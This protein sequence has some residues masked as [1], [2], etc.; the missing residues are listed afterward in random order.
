MR[1]IHI[2]SQKELTGAEAYAVHLAE[3][4]QALGH[5]VLIISDELHLPTN[6]PFES[7]SVHQPTRLEHY[8]NFQKLRAHLKA[9]QIHIIHAHSRAAVRLASAARRGTSVALITT[10]H[11]RQHFSWSKRLRD[12]YGDRVI[13]ICE[14]VAEHLKTDFKMNPRK[15]WT[16]RNPFHLQ[17]LKDLPQK[18]TQEPRSLGTD[19]KVENALKISYVGRFSGPKGEL[20]KAF[21]SKVFPALLEKFPT[22]AIDLIGRDAN[23]IDPKTL[24]DIQ[25]LQ[26]RFSNRFQLV[27]STRPLK[28]LWPTAGSAVIG[29]GRVAIEALLAGKNVFALGEA[30]WDGLVTKENLDQALSS[31]FGDIGY[32]I[33]EGIFD[34]TKITQEITDFLNCPSSKNSASHRLANEVN[35][36]V[37]VPKILRLYES[38]WFQKQKPA[39]I[40]ILMYH[41]VVPEALLGPHQTFITTQQFENHLKFFK[42]Q[43]FTPMT[44][45]ELSQYRT[46]RR[47]L[48][49]F[50]K[51]PIILTFDDGY[52]NNLKNAVPLLGQYKMKAVFFLLADLQVT[53]NSWDQE[54]MPLL[55]ATERQEL[56]KT[57]SEIASHGFRHERITKMTEDEALHEL[58]DSRRSLEDEFSRKILT[59]GFTYGDSN[60]LSA[61]LAENAGYE[62]AV[63]TDQGGLHLEEHPYQVFRINIF[64]KDGPQ[65][66]KKKTATWYR[67]YYLL[68][69]GK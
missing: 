9:G 37:L 28:D 56:A 65:Q 36:Q 5:Q 61:R 18:P 14:N 17:P 3:A 6:V 58:R 8:R 19:E 51:K 60:P 7:W 68:K 38:A 52:R 45:E 12:I 49:E 23:L 20:A 54:T 34:F 63:N 1:I 64:P 55:N 40:P 50:P 2:L 44:F 67:W 39:F 57:D 25:A 35:S 13:A 53:T 43:G 47:A 30:S 22:L 10:A 29:A 24:E 33:P 15:I 4:Q 62:Y 59:F 31:N 66:L 21:L 16:L 42:A 32:P 11:G 48:D 41:K 26:T 27:C 46:H 69:R